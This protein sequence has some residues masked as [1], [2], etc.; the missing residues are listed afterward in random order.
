M[1]RIRVRMMK[2]LKLAGYAEETQ[3]R[4]LEAADHLVR[5]HWRCPS[6]MGQEEV[7]EWVDHLVERGHIGPQRLR[8]HFA[9]LKFLFRKTLAKAEAVSFV[10]WPA[11]PPHLPTVL[12]ADEVLSLLN[13]L[14]STKYRVFFATMY[15]T[16]LRIGEACQLKTSDIDA[17]RGVIQVHGKGGRERLVP[18]N[19]RLL[20]ILRSYW[21]AERPPAPWLFASKRGNHLHPETART[22]L[23]R[24][25]AKAGLDKRVTP[26]VLRHSFATHLL[27]GGTDIR[28]IQVLLGHAS[29]SS[30]MRYVQVSSKV[31]AATKN[32]LDQLTDK[33]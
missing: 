29:I 1:N 22:A 26:H 8:Q 14:T 23:K 6:E 30:T 17:K 32:P 18:S 20:A 27:E 10:S 31:I 2:D 5:F 12:S 28:I 13:A 7:R 24:A 33:G 11:D 15:A 9:G 4:Y 16:G 19:E 21:A 25:T 3:R